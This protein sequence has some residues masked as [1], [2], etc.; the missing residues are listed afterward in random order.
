MKSYCGKENHAGGG[1][2]HGEREYLLSQ[3]LL[4]ATLQALI[5]AVIKYHYPSNEKLETQRHSITYQ[6]GFS[7]REGELTWI[8]GTQEG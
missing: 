8:R 4:G 5:N 1:G 3:Y 2:R 7:R 6:N